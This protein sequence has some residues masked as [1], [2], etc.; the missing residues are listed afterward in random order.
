LYFNPEPHRHGP[1]RGAGSAISQMRVTSDVVQI[2][3]NYPLF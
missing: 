2:G 3:L 1:L